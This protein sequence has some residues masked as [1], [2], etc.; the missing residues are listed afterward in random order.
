MELK[1]QFKEER[2]R[3]FLVCMVLTAGVFWVFG[4]AVSYDFL[5]YDDYVYIVDNPH[6]K[7]GLTAEAVRWAFTSAY[8]NFWHPVTWLSYILDVEI[9]GI[10]PIGFHFTNIILHYLN[11]LSLFAVLYY[12]TGA[13]GPC[14]A[15]GLLFGIHPLHVE[16]VAWVSERKDVLSAFFM[17]LAMGAYAAYTKAPS[18]RRYAAVTLL[19]VLGLMS[20][21]MVV[22]LPFVFLL[23]DYWPLKRT[24]L[25]YRESPRAL[26]FWSLIKEKIPFFVLAFVFSIVAVVAQKEGGALASVSEIDFALRI[27]NAFVSYLLYLKNT[28]FPS[29]L[30]I[31]YPYAETLSM[32]PAVG[33]AVFILVVCMLVLTFRRSCPWLLTG[34]FW[35]LG[36][37]VPVIGIV[38]VGDFSMA[39]RFTYIPLVGIF[40][41][42]V[43]TAQ[44][45]GTYRP[46]L[47]KWIILFFVGAVF[48]LGTVAY[49]Q[50]GY[51]KN[52]LA[53]FEHAVSV[54]PENWLALNN[55][56]VTYNRLGNPQKAVECFQKALVSKPVFIEAL[57]NLAGTLVKTG[58]MKEALCYYY[59]AIEDMPGFS[60]TY[61]NL[62][63]ALA[64]LGQYT[65]AEESYKKALEINPRDAEALNNLGVLQDRLQRTGEGM[66][67]IERALEIDP[68]YAEA[69]Y[70]MGNLLLKQSILE[71]AAY[72][73][74]HAIRIRADYVEAYNNLGVVRFNMNRQK[75]AIALF[76]AALRIKPDYSDAQNNLK[77][78]LAVVGD[79][80]EVDHKN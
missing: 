58:H 27:K 19:F 66:K 63:V 46:A 57:N 44:K 55:L 38:Q 54:N 32:W 29:K 22:T 26:G 70:N 36:T 56:G 37:L 68:Y 10:E 13:L 12:M 20:K 61:Y 42:L 31:F 35:Y 17:I 14:L 64:A 40:I 50:V 16:S 62:A 3:I 48:G 11:C 78:A 75:E 9:F 74:G 49:R 18:F 52:S 30:S 47:K 15:V 5:T 41:M 45:A 53:L 59:R 60:G 72:H 8:A 34:W 25:T 51:F 24:K 73:Y 6:I 28:I 4:R 33:A 76:E 43:L 23:L 2:A 79:V 69:H 39:D 21:P 7:D 65:E 71:K 80:D 77:K 67:H 1:K